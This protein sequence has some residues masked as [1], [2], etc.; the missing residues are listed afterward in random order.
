MD[1]RLTRLEELFSNQTHAIEQMSLEM[2]QQQKEISQ[3]KQHLEV[4]KEKLEGVSDGNDIAG[5]E[6]PPHY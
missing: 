3:L 2:F 4:L 6:R 1:D 5:S